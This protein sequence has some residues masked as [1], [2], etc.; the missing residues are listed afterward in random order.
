MAQFHQ[1]IGASGQY[2]AIRI[3]LPQTVE[4]GQCM[5]KQHLHHY[6]PLLIALAATITA[7]TI[8]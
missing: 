4:L 6:F 8:F 3:F 7:S 5:G 2:P 1:Q